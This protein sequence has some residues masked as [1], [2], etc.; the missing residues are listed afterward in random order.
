LLAIYKNKFD[1]P[2]KNDPQADL[3]VNGDIRAHNLDLNG[4]LNVNG[5]INRGGG[6]GGDYSG[7]A[8]FLGYHTD[9]STKYDKDKEIFVNITGAPLNL[10]LYVEK[11]LRNNGDMVKPWETAWKACL[12]DGK[13]LLE[14]GEFYS[15]CKVSGLI[16]TDSGNTQMAKSEWAGNFPVG[17][18]TYCTSSGCRSGMSGATAIVM[19]GACR[20]NIGGAGGY[21]SYHSAAYRCVR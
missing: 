14:L 3:D 5:T 17:Y 13:R 16:L 18:Y 9:D 10:G 2:I 4:N 1:P 12:T 19:G 7:P 6:G 8:E 11:N 15:A 21:Y 20:P